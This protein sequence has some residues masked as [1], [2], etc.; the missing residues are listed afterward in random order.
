MFPQNSPAQNGPQTGNQF[1]TSAINQQ[2]NGLLGA[3][4]MQFNASNPIPM[5][6]TAPSSSTTN[7]QVANMIKALKG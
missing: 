1:T 4:Q 2:N 3:P 6:S 5:N 7:P